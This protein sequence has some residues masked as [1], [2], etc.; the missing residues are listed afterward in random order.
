MRGHWGERPGSNRDLS[1]EHVSQTLD[2]LF[3]PLPHG[4]GHPK[5]GEPTRLTADPSYGGRL[6]HQRPVH[7]LRIDAELQ[8]ET[9]GQRRHTVHATSTR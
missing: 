3:Q 5:E 2:D 4:V 9:R 6:N 1:G 7:V 8:R